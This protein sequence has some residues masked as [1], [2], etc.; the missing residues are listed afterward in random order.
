[1]SDRIIVHCQTAAEEVKHRLKT[2]KEDKICIIPHGHFAGYYPNKISRDTA[3][4]KLDINPSK[5]TF[6]FIGEIRYYKGVLELIDAF[7]LLSNE[8]SELFIVGKPHDEEIY[9]EVRK[10]TFNSQNIVTEFTY[11]SRR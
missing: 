5:L 7:K 6:L 9:D 2:H 1:M 11:S 4:K 8:T 10:K 3:R